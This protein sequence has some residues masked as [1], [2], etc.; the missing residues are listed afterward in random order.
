VVVPAAPELAP[1]T[2]QMSPFPGAGLPPMVSVAW[3]VAVVPTFLFCVVGETEIC[4]CETMIPPTG[5]GATIR[6]A[7]L[8]RARLQQQSEGPDDGPCNAGERPQSRR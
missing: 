7:S 2:T 3:I 5:H 1:L 8:E 4:G 6:A